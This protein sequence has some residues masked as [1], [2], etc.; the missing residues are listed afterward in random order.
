MDSQDGDYV[1][2]GSGDGCHPECLNGC[3]GGA[4]SHQCIG[5]RNM[6]H[7]SRCVARCPAGSFATVDK[8]C[9]RCHRDCVTCYG[10]GKRHCVACRSRGDVRA[11]VDVSKGGACVARCSKGYVAANATACVECPP[12]CDACRDDGVTCDA[13]AQNFVLSA[14]K[15]CV[16]ACPEGQFADAASGACMQCHPTCTTCVGPRPSQCGL[17]RDAMFY[18]ERSCV[19]KCPNGFFADP[20]ETL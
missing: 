2:V 20:G 19:D 13:C 6:V 16:A 3:K 15:R 9:L 14:D 10:P 11:V 18:Y 17:C 4:G 5:C 7:E 8:L 1:A 12:H